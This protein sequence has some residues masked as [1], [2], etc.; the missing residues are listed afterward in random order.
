V[1]HLEGDVG[2]DGVA[3]DDDLVIWAGVAFV[4]AF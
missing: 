4:V 2:A 3:H 1:A